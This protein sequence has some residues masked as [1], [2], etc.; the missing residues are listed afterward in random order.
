MIVSFLERGIGGTNQREELNPPMTLPPSDSAELIGSAAA[1]LFAAVQTAKQ[2]GKAR[3][4]WAASVSITAS[5]KS[6]R[7]FPSGSLGVRLRRFLPG[8]SMGRCY[9]RPLPRVTAIVRRQPTSSSR[10]PLLIRL[11]PQSSALLGSILSA[12]SGV[13]RPASTSS[14]NC[15]RRA[16]RSSYSSARLNRDSATR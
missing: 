7:I 5:T 12:R 13:Q 11:S 6:L 1:S 2:I 15:L 10:C 14:D 8:A 3:H 16:P 4:L 9:H